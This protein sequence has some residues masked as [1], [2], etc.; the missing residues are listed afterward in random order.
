M[1]KLQKI[2]MLKHKAKDM[3]GQ[4]VSV[5]GW[6]RTVRQSKN[7]AFMELADGSCFGTV[8]VVLEPEV[9]NNYQ[10]IV[11][12]NVG[13]AVIVMGNV[14]YTPDARQPF[15]IKALEVE[16]IKAL[17]I[18]KVETQRDLFRVD[19]NA[20]IQRAQAAQ[21]AQE[22]AAG[23]SNAGNVYGP[24]QI[25]LHVDIDKATRKTL[26]GFGVPEDMLR[27]TNEVKKIKTQQEQQSAQLAFNSLLTQGGGGGRNAAEAAQQNIPLGGPPSV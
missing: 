13:S 4:Q 3:D 25:A 16:K 21:E 27:S 18:E 2:K 10:E 11:K 17:G 22:I 5:G 26:I 6:V 7:F 20:A 15:E 14:V 23:I 19:V 12:L 9:L 1:E 24:Q 8:Q